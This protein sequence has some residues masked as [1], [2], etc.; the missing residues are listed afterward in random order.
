[1][2]SRTSLFASRKLVYPAFALLGL[3]WGT[4]FIF[5]K[6]AAAWITPSQVVLL[7][8]LFGFLPVLALAMIR[9]SLRWEHLRYI[10]HFLMMA[11]L[12][13]A[14]YYFAF[15][16]G[17]ALL[18]SG[19]AGMLSGAIPLFSFLTALVFLRQEP[20]NRYTAIGLLLGFAGVLL[21]AKPWSPSATGVNLQGVLYMLLGS[22]SVGCSFVYARKFLVPKEISPLALTT[23]QIGLAFLLMCC[24][25]DFNGITH[26]QE[27]NAALAGL[28]LGLGLSGTGLA[29][30][31]YYFIVQ[32]LGA[33]RAAGVT[34]IPPI[35]ALA[36]GGLLVHEPL[37]SQ[38]V[39]AMFLILSGVYVLQTGQRLVQSVIHNK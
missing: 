31:L 37:S 3:I 2:E 39:V 38:D 27:D 32:H 13:T 28:V 20:I 15:A 5:M 1:M 34:Y 4:N 21:I 12:A 24:A 29:Y 35:V 17:T 7:R 14:I 9:R 8:V 22:I 18:P 26:I 36:I 6:W 16:K 23:Y 30:V 25:T 19:I 33:L 11:L 10:H